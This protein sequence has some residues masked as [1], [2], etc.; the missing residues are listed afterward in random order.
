MFRSILEFLALLMFFAVARA[1]IG[2]L[3]RL[4][5]GPP[6]EPSQRTAE[7]SLQTASELKRDPVCGTYVPTTTALKKTVKGETVYFC[8]TD[9]RDKFKA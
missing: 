9:C 3:G 5:A 7:S 4:F 1:A 8:S 6:Q 2:A